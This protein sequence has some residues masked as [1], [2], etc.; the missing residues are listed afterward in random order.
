MI[1]KDMEFDEVEQK[2]KRKRDIKAYQ[3]LMEDKRRNRERERE[4]DAA[5]A[6]IEQEEIAVRERQRLEEL[7]IEEE[8]HK[9]EEEIKERMKLKKFMEMQDELEKQQKAKEQEEAVQR[10]LAE[11][12]MQ[13]R[14]KLS[15]NE[16]VLTKGNNPDNELR[17]KLEQLKERQDGIQQEII[18]K[19][20]SLYM[21][22]PRER[23]EVFGAELDWQLLIKQG[24]IERVVRPWVAKK[25]K[26]YLGVEE[27]AMIKLVVNQL[28]SG[29]CSPNS[30][31]SKVGN[32][33]DEVAEQFVFKLWQVLIFEHLKIKE[34]IYAMQ[35]ELDEQ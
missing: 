15:E 21:K 35:K 26:E 10:I 19:T 25:I 30:L 4:E 28:S 31:L 16:S 14:Q 33:L 11:Q 5:D 18:Q 2:R 23:N 7:R 22:L 1:K 34:G 13:K 24:V 20:K 12:Q 3:R 27:P 6:K 29:N 9:R 17:M 8:K 32:I